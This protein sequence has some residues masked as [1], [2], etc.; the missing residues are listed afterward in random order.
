VRG[1][2]RANGDVGD[3]SRR[4]VCAAERSDVGVSSP[5]NGSLIVSIETLAMV[6]S[7]SNAAQPGLLLHTGRRPVEQL[8]QLLPLSLSLSLAAADAAA[9]LL[10]LPPH[11]VC[12]PSTS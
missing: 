9:R 6:P 7:S 11:V 10:P 12:R 5:A 3:C 1:R 8:E 4:R 2:R